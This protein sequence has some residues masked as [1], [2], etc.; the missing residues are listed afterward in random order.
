MK[1]SRAIRR[2][3]EPMSTAATEAVRNVGARLLDD[4]EV[5]VLIGYEHREGD[6]Q[7]RPAFALSPGEADRMV[8]DRTCFHNLAVYLPQ[9]HVRAM[10]RTG[11]V[12]KGC[13]VRAINVLLREHV[14]ERE[15]VFLIGVCCEGVGEPVLDK[16]SGCDAQNPS[17]CDEVVGERVSSDSGR[18][19]S[20][21]AVAPV[22]A[23]SLEERRRFWQRHFDRCIRCYACRQVC[24]LCYCSRCIVEK[25][26]PRWVESSAHR[27]GNLAWS[28][29]R[30]FHLTGRCVGCGEC[31]RACPVDI[32]LTALNQ[33]MASL[34]EEWFDF[35]SGLSPEQCAP[36]STWAE[37]DP[38]KD[39]L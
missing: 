28:V 34:I 31:E 9:E 23:M 30:A 10:G 24:P 5:G 15:D 1:S 36:F 29:T 6:A 38:E 14:I 2:K 7:A 12:V 11:V 22:E 13:D 33:K 17:G 32:P 25:T 20:Y 3:L 39:I 18:E 26:M 19:R 4:E 27:R 35:R 21:P 37:D 16:C 8:F